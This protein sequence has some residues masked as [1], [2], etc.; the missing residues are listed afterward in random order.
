MNSIILLIR[1]AFKNE[2][3]DHNKCFAVLRS[4]YKIMILTFAR[5]NLNISNY[6]ITYK[7]KSFWEGNICVASVWII[8]LS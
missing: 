8:V 7:L 1:F 2:K 4:N 6:L 3:F 5:D